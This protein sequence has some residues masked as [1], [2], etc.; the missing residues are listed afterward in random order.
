PKYRH[1]IFGFERIKVVCEKSFYETAEKYGLIIKE[2][3]FDIDHLHMVIDIPPRYSVSQ[4]VKFLKGRSSRRLFKTFPWLRRKFF[5]KGGLWSPAYYFDSI[6]DVQSEIIE[7][8][9]REQGIKGDQKR[10]TDYAA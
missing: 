6:G 8:Y 2:L 9:V 1:K 4:V 7:R 5:L 10:L 3:G